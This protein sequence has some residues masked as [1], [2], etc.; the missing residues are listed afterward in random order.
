MVPAIRN[1]IIKLARR[2]LKA[3]VWRV[4]CHTVSEECAGCGLYSVAIFWGMILGKYVVPLECCHCWRGR[5]WIGYIIVSI[6]VWDD[7][8]ATKL[9]S[10]GTEKYKYLFMFE[11]RYINLKVT[12][13]W[14]DHAFMFEELNN[15]KSWRLLVNTHFIGVV[16]SLGVDC[17]SSQQNRPIRIQMY[18]INC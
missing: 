3:K 14:S 1:S 17:T 8:P 18:V 16:W 2:S 6:L 5:W 11:D 13:W 15:G 12:F 4:G 9:A 7:Q 10:Y